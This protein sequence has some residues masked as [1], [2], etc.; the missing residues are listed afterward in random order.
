MSGNGND[1]QGKRIYWK[2]HKAF[3]GPGRA[4]HSQYKDESHWPCANPNIVS[5]QTAEARAGERAGI[6]RGV[7]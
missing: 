7:S 3:S 2:W 5:T 4:G 6:V 1:V